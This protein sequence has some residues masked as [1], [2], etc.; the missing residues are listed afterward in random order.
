MDVTDEHGVGIPGEKLVRKFEFWDFL[1]VVRDDSGACVGAVAQDMKSMQIRAFPADAVCSRR[2]A[3]ASSS[4][5]R[6]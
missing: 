6:R 5:A 2:A 1:S 3:T 4:G